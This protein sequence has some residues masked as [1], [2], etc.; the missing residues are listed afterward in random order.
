M[1]DGASKCCDLLERGVEIAH[2]KVGQRER[3]AR[4]TA[5][6]MNADE[7]GRLA[8]LPALT[9]ALRAS[10]QFDAQEP[11]PEPARALGVI[12]RK[13]NQRW[14]SFHRADDTRRI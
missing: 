2:L 4:A 7:G 10:R 3:V 8:G 12:G 11:R 13:L 5:A 14:A 1:H 6:G 9:F